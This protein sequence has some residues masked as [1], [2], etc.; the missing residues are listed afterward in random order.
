[1]Y[2]TVQAVKE[3]IN[4]PS[5]GAPIEDATIAGFILDAQDEI[6]SIYKTKFGSVEVN[7]VATSS[8]INVLTDSEQSLEDD[9]LYG[10]ILWIYSGTGEGQY[11]Q[12]IANT[13][14]T[15]TVS[16]VFTV[17]P[18]ATSK[19]KVVKLGYHNDIIDGSGTRKQFVT[20]QP[21]IKLNNLV[22]DSV[23]VTPSLVYQDLSSGELELGKPDV[24]VGY[25]SNANPQLVDIK[26]IYGVYPVPRVIQRL[27]TVLAGARTLISQISGTY[28]DFSTISLPGGFSGS[29]GEPYVNIRSALD[30][31]QGEARGIIYGT[32]STGQV[33][34]D[35]RTQPSYRPYTLFG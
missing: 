29:K 10:Y 31:L 16:D 12:I 2:T 33:S 11:R 9:E 35:F 30:Y 13:S 25:F 3:A 21:L 32:Q 1:M 24:E 23:E 27:A 17:I 14:T 26:Y 20:R 6:E 18:D 19:Y 5:T 7:S 15:Y 34:G 4:Y 8:T 28:D 22:I